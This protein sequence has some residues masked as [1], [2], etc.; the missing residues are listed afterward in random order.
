MFHL[1]PKEIVVCSPGRM[2]DFLQRGATPLKLEMLALRVPESFLVNNHGCA[3]IWY[4]WGLQLSSTIGMQFEAI[5]LPETA[6]A[7]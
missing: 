2:D 1:C 7:V 3:S 4:V 6:V 5:R